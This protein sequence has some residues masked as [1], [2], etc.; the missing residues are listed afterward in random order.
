M[1]LEVLINFQSYTHLPPNS[2]A[3]PS[4]QVLLRHHRH[5]QP[6]TWRFC[7]HLCWHWSDT[8]LLADFLYL[9]SV[10]FNVPPLIAIAVVGTQ[11]VLAI[12]KCLSIWQVVARQVLNRVAK[13]SQQFM[14]QIRKARQV[15]KPSG[16]CPL[17][18]G[19]KLEWAM[20]CGVLDNI[21][22]L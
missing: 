8:S 14:F 1:I 7:H 10:C 2:A 12:V 11:L 4:P 20:D 19:L 13:M 18:V 6:G 9:Y 22:S 21:T 16:S 3:L 5:M 15:A 17:F